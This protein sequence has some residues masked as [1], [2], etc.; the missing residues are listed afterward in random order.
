MIAVTATSCAFASHPINSADGWDVVLVCAVTPFVHIPPSRTAGSAA[1]N[2]FFITIS[3]PTSVGLVGQ[4]RHP[5]QC[6]NIDQPPS[7]N[8]DR[9]KYDLDNLFF[10]VGN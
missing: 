4:I 7:I 1:M 8:V 2:I 10:R 9:K 5:N 6:L 3:F